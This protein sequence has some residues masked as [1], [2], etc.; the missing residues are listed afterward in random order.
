MTIRLPF[1]APA[2]QVPPQHW[3]DHNEETHM[4]VATVV[5]ADTETHENLARVVN[6]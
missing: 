2:P 5:L 6:A 3:N 4:K 1:R